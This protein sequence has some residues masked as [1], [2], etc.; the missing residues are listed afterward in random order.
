MTNTKEQQLQA[1]AR[2][3]VRVSKALWPTNVSAIATGRVAQTRRRLVVTCRHWSRSRLFA[4]PG[5]RTCHSEHS[6][7]SFVPLRSLQA[8]P[9]DRLQG[10]KGKRIGARQKPT[11]ASPLVL[12]TS[13][14]AMIAPGVIALVLAVTSL[15]ILMVSR[16]WLLLMPFIV[17][18]VV[19][20]A[21]VV[22]IRE[23]G[24]SMRRREQGAERRSFPGLSG[25]MHSPSTP[26]PLDPPLVR[27]LE[28][29]DL[30][31]TNIEHFLDLPES[32]NTG[33]YSLES[34]KEAQTSLP[35]AI[36]E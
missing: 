29:Y 33:G 4:T 36:R 11:R 31:Q 10:R 28:T 9:G 22:L 30:S 6:E 14:P 20:L 8:S 7:E 35:R 5:S 25:K 1:F 18:L 12:S 15:V 21:L 27:V 19:I 13:A 2:R 26:M 16:Q 24:L 34:W 3:A 17:V 32:G 23:R